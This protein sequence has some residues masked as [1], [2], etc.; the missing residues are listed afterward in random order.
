M[1]QT[2]I[3]ANANKFYYVQLLQTANNQYATWTRW[4]R[5]G[6]R[7]QMKMVAGPMGNLPACMYEFESKFKTKSGLAWA[8]RHGAPR[9]GKYTYVE[10]TYEDDS[11]DEGASGTKKEEE[12]DNPIPDSKIDKALQDLM[13]LIFNIGFL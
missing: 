12:E 8:D 9:K 10:K 2:N 3:G 1:N 5:V 4:G 11:G 13:T 6:E 7:G